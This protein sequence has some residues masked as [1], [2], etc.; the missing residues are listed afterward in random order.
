MYVYAFAESRCNQL[1]PDLA[2]VQ[3][4]C[5]RTNTA[6]DVFGTDPI[7]WRPHI[8]QTEGRG[9]FIERQIMIKWGI[10]SLTQN[11]D[12]WKLPQADTVM[13]QGIVDR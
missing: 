13:T 3:E 2:D 7:L 10:Y 9:R 4:A 11:A 1:G 12:V 6:T 8:K 5:R